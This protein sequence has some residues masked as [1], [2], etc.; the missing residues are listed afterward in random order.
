MNLKAALLGSSLPAARPPVLSTG[1]TL[2]N[3]ALSGKSQAGL[4]TGSVVW[5]E[6]PSDS[7]RSTFC[8]TLLAEASQDKAFSDYLLVYDDTEG[9]NLDIAG[10]F[11]KKVAK[12]IVR[13]S[14]YG[15]KNFWDGLLEWESPFVYVL[16]SLDGLCSARNGWQVNNQRAS[17]AFDAVRKRHSLLILTAQEKC[18]EGRKK[19][20]AGGFAVRFYADYAIK[21]ACRG[22]INRQA[23]GKERI[24]GTNTEIRVV[25]S[26]GGLKK[27]KTI[28]APVFVGCGY[29]NAESLLMFLLRHKVAKKQGSQYEIPAFGVVGTLEEILVFI[30]YYETS[31]IYLVEGKFA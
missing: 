4:P 19:V 15:V 22:E 25:K 13:K 11:G 12:R 30:R 3:L 5:V 7:G 24:V 2:L 8:L 18:V 29:D 10:Y 26:N 27:I 28:P 31:V 16:D 14:S 9:Q 21:T 23:A 1:L 20:T 6:G 17:A